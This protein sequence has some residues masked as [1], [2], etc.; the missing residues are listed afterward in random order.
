MYVLFYF[1][2]GISCLIEISFDHIVDYVRKYP[3]V[4]QLKIDF[5]V[6]CF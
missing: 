4:Q 1:V 2:C 6:F 5:D 3:V